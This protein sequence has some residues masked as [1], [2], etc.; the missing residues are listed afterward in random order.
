MHP[1]KTA[2][3][4]EDKGSDRAREGGGAIR[5]RSPDQ[6]RLSLTVFRDLCA[7]RGH[8]GKK[9]IVRQL[10]SDAGG[11]VC[12]QRTEF[13]SGV[14]N[15]LMLGTFRQSEL[16]AYPLNPLMLDMP[17]S[18]PAP[19]QSCCGFSFGQVQQSRQAERDPGMW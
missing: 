9:R 6:L 18:Q 4:S 8:I 1:S 3:A 15:S 5:G 19:S 10:D 2:I 11:S 7:A 13:R 14:G 12:R 16:C 17:L